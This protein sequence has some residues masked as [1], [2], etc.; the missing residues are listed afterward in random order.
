MTDEFLD[1]LEVTLREM[2][3]ELGAHVD[4]YTDLLMDAG[5][6]PFVILVQEGEI[7]VNGARRFS[8]PLAVPDAFER[9][10]AFVLELI[11]EMTGKTPTTLGAHTS[12]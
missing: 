5:G 8:V 2:A 10:A 6:W 7:R 9:F 3:V 11:G 1:D 4:E 12:S